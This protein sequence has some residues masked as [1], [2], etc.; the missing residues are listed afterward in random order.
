MKPDDIIKMAREAGFEINSLGWTYTQGFLSEHLERFAA[1]VAAH[2]RE[3]CANLLLNVDL[4]SM[5]ADHR[6]QRW[7]ATVL[8]NFSDAIRARGEQ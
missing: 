7:T 5:D 4:S 3:A 1:L 2:E 6:L 8:L